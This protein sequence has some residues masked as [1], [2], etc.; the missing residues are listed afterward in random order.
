[1]PLWVSFWYRNKV[2]F[3]EPREPIRSELLRN[4][5][6]TPGG[7]LKMFHNCSSGIRSPSIHIHGPAVSGIGLF[8]PDMLRLGNAANPDPQ[9]SHVHLNVGNRQNC[10]L[11]D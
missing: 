11:A 3:P 9:D 1:M 5:A 10:Q 8:M 2:V 7:D 6:G 4:V